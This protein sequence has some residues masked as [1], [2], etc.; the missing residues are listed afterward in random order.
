MFL[1][2]TCRVNL[3]ATNTVKEIIV[4]VKPLIGFTLVFFFSMSLGWSFLHSQEKQQPTAA[5]ASSP[6]PEPA[7]NTSAN[8]VEDME[9]PDTGLYALFPSQVAFVNGKAI[10]GRDLSRLIQAELAPIGNPEWQN[11]REDY[12][13]QLINQSLDSLIDGELIYQEAIASGIEVTDDEV[14]K[15][16]AEISKT[17]KNDA[18]MNV[19]LA[20]QGTDREG[21]TKDLER[22]LVVSKFVAKN[23]SDKI[24]ISSDELSQ[25]YSSHPDEFR[26][27][28]IVRTS[29]ILIIVAEGATSEQD[30]LAKER[31][32]AILARVKKGEDFAKLA[33][34]YSM[35]SSA[36][37]GGDIGFTSKDSVAPEYAEVA[38]SLPVEGVSEVFRSQFG[39]HIIKVT[40]KKK[41][42]VS[43]LEEVHSQLSDF[44]K[45][46]KTQKDLAQMIEG[47]RGKAKIEILIE[48]KLP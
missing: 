20:N 12:R 34:E 33:K 26:H 22:N 41:E 37:Q 24:V 14:Q 23:I 6:T 48:I 19:A 4:A 28:D 11:L 1:D 21:F 36:S 39:Y 13:T 44:L 3:N 45:S 15:E 30:K 18:E 40:D 8:S 35:D 17:F 10:L 5:I 2:A 42:G 7:S 32:E 25:Y 29:H 9:D 46:Q 16:L 31:A 43:T 47:L 38:F 27:P